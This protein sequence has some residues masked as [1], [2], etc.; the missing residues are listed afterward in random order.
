[1][2]KSDLRNIILMPTLDSDN[3]QH[4]DPNEK[5]KI[6]LGSTNQGLE[7]GMGALHQMVLGWLG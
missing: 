7:R 4:K 5:T 3:L 6:V 1:M 2:Q